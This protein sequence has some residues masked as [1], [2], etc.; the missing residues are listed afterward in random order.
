ML[1]RQLMRHSGP[2][3]HVGVMAPSMSRP[4]PSYHRV[5]VHAA[6]PQRCLANPF[7]RCCFGYRRL[8]RCIL[9]Y[10]VLRHRGGTVTA[11]EKGGGGVCCAVHPVSEARRTF[12]LRVTLHCGRA[13]DGAGFLC[14]CVAT[15][16][17]LLHLPKAPLVFVRQ[18]QEKSTEPKVTSRHLN[19]VNYPK[20]E[21]IHPL[22][23]SVCSPGTRSPGTRNRRTWSCG[24]AALRGLARPRHQAG[25]R[26]TFQVFMNIGGGSPLFVWVV[27]YAYVCNTKSK[28]G[29]SRIELRAA[30]FVVVTL[31]WSALL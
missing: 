21:T 28:K 10:L 17:I 6:H 11:T 19:T 1:P 23:L 14:S 26:K 7:L 25:E 24:P 27:T 9:V 15:C 13:V 5:L 3:R 12:G 18:G 30:L 16:H 20:M 31:F 29:Y 2:M 4:H 8:G 22:P